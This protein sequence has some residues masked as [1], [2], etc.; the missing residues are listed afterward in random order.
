MFLPEGPYVSNGEGCWLEK[1][2]FWFKFPQQWSSPQFC[3]WLKQCPQTKFV[4]IVK[5]YAFWAAMISRGIFHQIQ[6]QV[7]GST[8]LIRLLM[9]KYYIISHGFNFAGKSLVKVGITAGRA[10]TIFIVQFFYK[11]WTISSMRA[12]VWKRFLLRLDYLDYQIWNSSRVDKSYS[13]RCSLCLVLKSGNN[14]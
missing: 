4:I 10:K 14:Y 9:V 2:F 6:F 8:K 11:I 3:C 12:Y 13:F 5:T 7:S 1:R